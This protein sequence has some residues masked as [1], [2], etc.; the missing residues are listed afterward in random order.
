M[1]IIRERNSHIWQLWECGA[2]T[3]EVF[4]Q[5]RKHNCY[6]THTVDTKGYVD[7]VDSKSKSGDLWDLD[8]TLCIPSLYL[9]LSN[10]G[11]FVFS[12]NKKYD[13]ANIL[14]TLQ[15]KL[16]EQKR[17]FIQEEHGLHINPCL[18]LRN[19]MFR[20]G[21]VEDHLWLVQ[22]VGWLLWVQNGGNW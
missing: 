13:K 21:S 15:N 17:N 5:A 18:K 8:T 16:T 14:Q 6:S 4:W 7:T 9:Y 20:S 1:Q 12:G 10:A 2:F 22:E 19:H 11:V 3:F